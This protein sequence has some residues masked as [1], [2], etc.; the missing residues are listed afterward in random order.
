MT[1][2]KICGIRRIEDIE[3]VNKLLPDYIGFVF[4]KSRRQIEIKDA[5]GLSLLT[6][7]RIKKIGVFVNEDIK[8]VKEI[9]DTVKLYALQFHGNEDEEYVSNF[10]E[11]R[12]WKSMS[13]DVD[14][15]NIED[16]E[17]QIS[18]INESLVQSVVLD[19]ISKSKFGGSGVSFDWDIV[20]KLSI[21]KKLI[22]AGGLNS[23]NVLEAINKA[24]PYAVDVS[25]GVE[26]DGFKDF[27][28]IKKFI[29]K[30]RSTK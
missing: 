24:K 4:A 27:Y 15:V 23:N 30:V 19:S 29:E 10:K 14:T 26:T 16:Y 1:K 17:K 9:A 8:V 28:K 2:I 7:N 3:Y 25:S 12:V 6:D 20:K 18:K 21:K 11:Y 13:I 22:L 5:K